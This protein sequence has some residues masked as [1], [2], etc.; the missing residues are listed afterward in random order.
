MHVCKYQRYKH[1]QP[2]ILPNYF[3]MDFASF[4][5]FGEGEEFFVS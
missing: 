4:F 3:S 2:E 1:G 5:L